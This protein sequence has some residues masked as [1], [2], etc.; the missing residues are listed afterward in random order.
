MFNDSEKSIEICYRLE[1][2]L[3]AVAAHVVQSAYLTTSCP[4]TVIFYLEEQDHFEKGY[5]ARS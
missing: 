4:P 5:M 3:L 2:I 1:K